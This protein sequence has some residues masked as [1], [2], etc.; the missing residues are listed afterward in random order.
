MMIKTHIKKLRTVNLNERGQIVI[1]ED[2]RKDFG[3]DKATTLVLIEKKGEIVLKKE[4]D[5]LNAIEGEDRLWN[6]LQGEAI[7]KAWSKEDEVWD[8]IYRDSNK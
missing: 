4:S 6:A 3:L 7:K 5:V 2:V 1:P 8:K